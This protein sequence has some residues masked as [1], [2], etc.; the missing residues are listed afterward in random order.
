MSGWDFDSGKSGNSMKAEFTKFPVGITRIRV[1]DGEPFE[2]WSHYMPSLKRSV[3]CPG[4]EC[5]ICE[6][7]RQQR[8]N[9]QPY[10]YD[11]GRRLV[12][13]V[14]N[15]ETDRIEIMDQGITFYQ[16]LR[17]I[18]MDLKEEG[19]T[20]N[21]V[22]L[23][24]RRRGMGKDDTSYRID[25]DKE[26]PLS[27]DDEKLIEG[28]IDLPQYFTPHSPEKILRI[29]QG[30]DWNDVFAKGEEEVEEEIVIH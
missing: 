29:I 8:A 6:I 25:V 2:R 3:N 12:M 19:K 9:K 21:D 27:A 14:I 18:M 10:T 11:G 15:R 5:P 17:D 23:K 28:K 4:R 1:I 13:N 26:Y 22:D 16:D 30:E 20:L 7:R 24:I